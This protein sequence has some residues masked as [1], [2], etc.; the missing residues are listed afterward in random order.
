MCLT[1]SLTDDRRTASSESKQPLHASTAP[2]HKQ[3]RRS[4]MRTSRE[5]RVVAPP[6]LI[7]RHA[8]IVATT[9]TS[10]TRQRSTPTHLLYCIFTSHTSRLHLY[11]GLIYSRGVPNGGFRLFG[12]IRIRIR[13]ALPAEHFDAAPAVQYLP[14]PCV[15]R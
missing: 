8:P 10:A 11:I 9:R 12:R 14:P 13:I 7:D 6:T 2:T 15:P 4:P 1:A 5:R 3:Q